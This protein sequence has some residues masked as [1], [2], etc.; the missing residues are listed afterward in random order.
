MRNISFLALFWC[1]LSIYAQRNDRGFNFGN[2]PL[3]TN[4]QGIA[5]W[6]LLTGFSDDFEHNNKNS[7]QFRNVWDE[8]YNPDPG[9]QGPGQTRWFIRNT[10]NDFDAGL[11]TVNNGNLIIRTASG[12]NGTVNCGII[13]SKNTVRYPIYTEA[14]IRVSNLRTSSNFWALNECD[15]E[16]IDMLECYG[17]DPDNFYAKQMSTNFHIWHRQG[18]QNIP[19]TDDLD[20]CGGLDITDFTYQTFFTT[21]P[22]SADFNSSATQFWRNDFHNFGVYWASPT[23][24]TF[25]IDGQPRFNGSHYVT[26]REA[27]GLNGS[28][29]DGVFQCPNASVLRCATEQPLANVQGQSA[30]GSR[31]PNRGLDDSTFLIL[32]QESH[33]GRTVDPASALNNQN[34]NGMVVQWVRTYRPNFNGGGNTGGNTGG[35]SSGQIIENGLYRITNPRLNQSLLAR[36]L[37]NHDARVVNTGNFADQQWRFQHLGNNVYTIKNNGTGRYL[38][39]QSAQCFNGANVKTWTNSNGDHKKWR[40][41][42]NGSNFT[43]KPTHCL[44][45]AMD[46]AGGQRNGEIHLW[47]ANPN[48]ANQVWSIVRLGNKALVNN[49]DNL[50]AYPTVLNSGENVTIEGLSGGNSIYVFNSLGQKV[51]ELYAEDSL[52]NIETYNFNSGVYFIQVDTNKTLKFI[53]K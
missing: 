37:E 43:L 30:G 42:R 23:S 26:G 12:Q 3:P 41:E 50:I 35:N 14:R 27:F 24:C 32:D 52:I 7:A 22:N 48:N 19:G 6:D 33:N 20:N 4:L 53:I 28:F 1:I 25:Y 29:E 49:T 18:V 44:S 9:F 16:E 47:A 5:S 11:V 8:R 34:R 10:P 13:S 46:V 17:G 15:N 31:Y 51:K 2:T 36:A 38:E 21:N 39:V 40:V 45:R